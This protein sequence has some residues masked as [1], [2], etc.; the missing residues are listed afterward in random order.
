MEGLCHNFF[1]PR[2]QI[3]NQELYQAP[4]ATLDQTFDASV[5]EAVTEAAAVVESPVN[6]LIRE[7]LRW[8]QTPDEIEPTAADCAVQGF[9]QL[10][11]L[12]RN[13]E[14]A[15]PAAPAASTTQT[16]LKV[17][18]RVML[19]SIWKKQVDKT[20]LRPNLFA[21]KGIASAELSVNQV[22]LGR[23]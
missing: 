12:N 3:L 11:N 13:N 2:D 22:R 1:H 23:A 17:H 4:D 8:V 9:Q 15:K 18:E 16:R 7:R 10:L 21:G 19:E 14:G 6:R 5:N 20:N